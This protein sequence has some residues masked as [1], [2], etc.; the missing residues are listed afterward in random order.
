MFKNNMSASASSET[1][2]TNLQL[3]I[4]RVY[5]MNLPDEDLLAIRRM[6]ARYLLDKVRQ[7]VNIISQERGYNQETLENWLAGES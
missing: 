4:L 7:R 3:E 1:P 2:F 5:A 6:I